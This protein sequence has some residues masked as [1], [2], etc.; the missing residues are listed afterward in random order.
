MRIPAIYRNRQSSDPI[1]R[2][3]WIVEWITNI[4]VYGCRAVCIPAD[5]RPFVAEDREL[6]IVGWPDDDDALKLH[7]PPNYGTSYGKVRS[8]SDRPSK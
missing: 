6:E 1:E 3:V 4:R 5:G 8:I 7:R 2:L